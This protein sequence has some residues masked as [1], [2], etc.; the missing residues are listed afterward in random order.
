MLHR[1][2]VDGGTGNMSGNA[3]GYI[4]C[5]PTTYFSTT[6]NISCVDYY[7]GGASPSITG[8]TSDNIQRAIRVYVE[9]TH[10]FAGW[11]NAEMYN[12]DLSGGGNYWTGSDG[13]NESRPD[14]YTYRIWKRVS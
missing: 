7:W 13:G 6:G 14:N 8:S 3:D 10:S 1:H 11:S 4:R 9:H 5:W 2:Y 12:W